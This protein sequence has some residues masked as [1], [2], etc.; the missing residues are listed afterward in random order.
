M[1]GSDHPVVQV[2]W[3][4]ATAYAKW[5]GKRLPTEAE[6]ECAARGGLENKRATRGATTSS[7]AGKWMANIWTGDFPYS[8]TGARTVLKGHRR[9]EDF[10]K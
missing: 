10:P 6:W 4:D 3:Y 5:A 8:K 2:S 7:W 9:W 1:A